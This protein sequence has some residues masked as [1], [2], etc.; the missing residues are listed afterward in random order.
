MVLEE[1]MHSPERFRL[2]NWLIPSDGYL[3]V[4][5]LLLATCS[6]FNT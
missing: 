6:E 1:V 2:L 3:P 4:M 5:L